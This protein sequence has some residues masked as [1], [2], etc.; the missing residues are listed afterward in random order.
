MN[1]V[2]NEIVVIQSNDLTNI[3]KKVTDIQFTG[4]NEICVLLEGDREIQYCTG[5]SIAFSTTKSHESLFNDD[6]LKSVHQVFPFG[7]RNT[8]YAEERRRFALDL[9][10]DTMFQ[11]VGAHVYPMKSAEQLTTLLRVLMSKEMDEVQKNGIIYYLL[12]DA[13]DELS[14][15]YVCYHAIPPTYLS[16][17][18][19]FWCLDHGDFQGAVMHL[20][21]PQAINPYHNSDKIANLLVASGQLKLALTFM[22]S[23]GVENSEWH[24]VEMKL[25]LEANLSDAFMFMRRHS[26][27]QDF[28]LLR[29]LIDSCFK[30]E[31][32]KRSLA[33]LPFTRDEEQVLIDYCHEP[34]NSLSGGIGFLL[35]YY[36]NRGRFAEAVSCYQLSWGMGGQEG[37]AE[38]RTVD[39]EVA[40]LMANLAMVLPAVQAKAIEKEVAAVRSGVLE[41]GAES[42]DSAPAAPVINVLLDLIAEAPKCTSK[43][44]DDYEAEEDSQLKRAESQIESSLME[45]VVVESPSSVPALEKILSD[46]VEQVCAPAAEPTDVVSSAEFADS[47]SGL[48]K[49]ISGSVGVMSAASATTTVPVVEKSKTASATITAPVVEKLETA[50]EAEDNRKTPVNVPSCLGDEDMAMEA[51][52]TAASMA[53]F[54]AQSASFSSS[55]QMGTQK[56][57]DPVVRVGSPFMKRPLTPTRDEHAASVGEIMNTHVRQRDASLTRIAKPLGETLLLNTV[58]ERSKAADVSEMTVT[59]SPIGKPGQLAL[60]LMNLSPFVPLEEKKLESVVVVISPLQNQLKCHGF[61]DDDVVGGGGAGSHDFETKRQLRKTPA[62]ATRKPASSAAAVAATVHSSSVSEGSESVHHYSLRTTRRTTTTAAAAATMRSD[63][64]GSSAAST[65]SKSRTIL[66]ESAI[67]PA[68][69]TTTA[70][71]PRSKRSSATATPARSYDENDDPMTLEELSGTPATAIT[72]TTKKKAGAGRVGAKS[73]VKVIPVAAEAVAPGSVRVTRR[74]AKL[75]E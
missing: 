25:K 35:M 23:V 71:T 3:A 6:L 36:I 53:S 34:S 40:S 1:V 31:T 16:I 32:Q 30:N 13:S 21:S 57:K 55:L 58:V 62:R 59:T 75:H 56:M 61:D 45:T 72:T 24:K 9:M 10:F 52:P 64:D 28:S 51:T 18:D 42:Q 7:G 50:G 4:T 14:M 54:Q 22:K 68:T 2:D 47:T 15:E 20:T 73:A 41:M 19:G 26:E 67:K 48:Q 17:L 29:L 38:A 60:P 70:K 46:H 37:T 33:L 69:A 8:A 66:P 49:I 27:K 5:P 43:D 74:T 44:A 39:E 12:K 11:V 63:F 65:P